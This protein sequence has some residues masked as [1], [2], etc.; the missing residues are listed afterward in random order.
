MS[1]CP[2]LG[3]PNSPGLDSQCKTDS[4]G[5]AYWARYIREYNNGNRWRSPLEKCPVLI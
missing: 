2:N 5:I 4:R 3:T 1:S